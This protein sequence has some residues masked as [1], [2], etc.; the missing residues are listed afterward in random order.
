MSVDICVLGSG[1]S[2]N[3][4]LARLNGVPMLIDAGLG[5][6]TVARRLKGTG[7]DVTDLRA[8]LLTHLDCDHF[9]PTWFNTLLKCAIPVYCHR[10]HIHAL[11]RAMA[12][13]S[14]GRDARLL[15]RHGLIQSFGDDAF[16]LAL[17]GSAATRVHPMPLQHDE[18]GT[19][20]FRIETP[21]HRMAYAT[22]LGRVTDAVIDH[23]T[24]VEVLVIESNY[25]RQL[26][27]AS[28]RPA[29][30]K[31]RIMGGSGHLSNDESFDAVSAICER[32]KKPPHHIVLL[33]LSRQCNHP[34]I[35]AETF[36]RDPHIARRLCITAHDQRT[37]WLTLDA[38]RPAAQRAQ[39][40]MFG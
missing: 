22:D 23:F 37:D 11:Y 14:P 35:V 10:N 27:L 24:D 7:V 34:S 16:T 18:S 13:S 12:A 15:Q 25:D 29:M 30:L 3:A 6:R 17:N 4:T 21:R 31:R 9:R 2:G 32:S 28:A 19:I 5:P 36:A 40:A 33:H 39:P 8:V 26:Q 20:G 38:K 1:S